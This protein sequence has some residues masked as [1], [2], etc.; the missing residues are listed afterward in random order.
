MNTN[1]I[2]KDAV[3]HMQVPATSFPT[4]YA[5]I[6]Y[7]FCSAQCQERFLENPHLYV[8][9]PGHE[10]PAHH[11][12]EVIKIR[13]FVLSTPLDAMQTERVKQALFEMMGIHEVCIEGDKIEIQYDLIQ[14]TAEQIAEKLGLIGA[15]LGGGWKDRIRL[16]F[17]NYLEECEI[18]NLEVENKKGCH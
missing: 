8:G 16:A 6:H 1:E 9:H 15:E 17:I 3:C 18:D 13:R 14:A 12:R 7:A 4:E 11:G 10:A 5:G 2:V